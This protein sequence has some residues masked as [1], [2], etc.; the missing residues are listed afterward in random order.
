MEKLKTPIVYG[1]VVALAGSILMLTLLALKLLGPKAIALENEMTGG[2][3]L[4]LMLYLLLLFAIYFA[5][6]KRKDVLG[7]GIQFKEALIQGFVVSLSTAVFSVVFTIVFYELLYPSYVAD[8]IEALRL[9]M[10]S[11]GVPVEKLNAKLEEKE[12]YLSTSTQ[13]MFSF[14]GNLI[15]GGAFTLLLSFFLKTS[16]ER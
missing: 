8:T 9:K 12:A 15:T 11:S 7:R 10:E 13:S 1:F 6:K 5:I 2:T 3:I 14:I 4:F 16:K